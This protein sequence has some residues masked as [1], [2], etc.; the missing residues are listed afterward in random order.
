MMAQSNYELV[1]QPILKGR[2]NVTVVTIKKESGTRYSYEQAELAGDR[3]EDTTEN[4]I[5]SV[6]DVLRTELDPASALVKTQ[7]KLEEAAAKIDDVTT[8]L[9]LVEKVEELTKRNSKIVY[10]MVLNSVMSKNI[11]YGTTYKELVELIPAA[12]NGKTYHANELFTIEDPNHAEVN[13][14]G[15]RVLVQ[16]NKDFTYN[17]EPVSDFVTD[18][19]LEQNGTGV[20]WKFEGKE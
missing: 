11:A 1:S 16:V 10:A 3:T 15:K 9:A 20:A 6:L 19:R 7:S 17:N 18:G 4:I 8:R 5:Q 12:E 13:G 14:E 2:E